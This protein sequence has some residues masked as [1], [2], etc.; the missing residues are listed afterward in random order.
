MLQ[1]EIR[2]EFPVCACQQI[3]IE[4]RSDTGGVVISSFDHIPIFAKIDTDE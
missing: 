3:Q 4:L 2:A 1:I